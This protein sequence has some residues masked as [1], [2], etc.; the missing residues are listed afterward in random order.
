MLEEDFSYRIE[1]ET[2]VAW[3]PNDI[4]DIGCDIWQNLCQK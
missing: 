4:M 2:V 3:L 1:I